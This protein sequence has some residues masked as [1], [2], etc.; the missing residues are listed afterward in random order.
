T[1][2]DLAKKEDR[3]V[4]FP[5]ADEFKK[6]ADTRK[7]QGTRAA[8]EAIAPLFGWY[9]LTQGVCG[10]LAT[11]T[12][13][14]WSWAAP[15]ARL[16]RVR[17]IVLVLALLTVVVGWPIERHLHALRAERTAARDV[18][19]RGHATDAQQQEANELAASF[20]RWHWL[21]FGLDMATVVLVT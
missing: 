2:E 1:F 17:V 16:P 7:E 14:N 13:L 3:P 12:A 9:F 18:V 15:Q 19:L 11:G 10:L 6:D 20:S 5:V 21:S 4:W 8:G